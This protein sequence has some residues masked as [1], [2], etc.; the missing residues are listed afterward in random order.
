MTVHRE[1]LTQY[2]TFKRVISGESV[3]RT[4]ATVTSCIDL[5]VPE[6]GTSSYILHLSGLGL[7]P[8]APFAAADWEAVCISG[9][10]PL[11][12]V[13]EDGGVGYDTKV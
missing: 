6:G 12:A 1:T 2:I 5:W 4:L 10:P 7:T 13:R 8:D 9:Q 3:I 11:Q